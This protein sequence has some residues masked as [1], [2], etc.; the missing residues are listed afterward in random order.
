MINSDQYPVAQSTISITAEDDSEVIFVL[1]GEISFSSP[2]SSVEILDGKGDF[3]G[4]ILNESKE[5]ASVPVRSP[6]GSDKRPKKFSSFD[7]EGY[8]L[9]ITSVNES[10]GGNSPQSFTLECTI[11]GDAAV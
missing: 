7:C 3:E 1:N 5:T 10:K 6:S 4:E 11:T 9:F 8:S 2:S